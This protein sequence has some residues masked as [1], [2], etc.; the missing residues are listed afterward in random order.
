MVIILLL[1]GQK[2]FTSSMWKIT[3]TV[4]HWPNPNWWQWCWWQL[5][6]PY[7]GDS[8]EMLVAEIFLETY[9]VWK[10]G[11]QHQKFVTNTN[12]LQIRHQHRLNPLTCLENSMSWMGQIQF[13]SASHNLIMAPPFQTF[14]S[15]W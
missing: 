11:R 6:E 3:K 2:P 5:Y 14:Q 4:S 7:D 15:K 8:F 9:S 13:F 12:Y 1:I 10:I